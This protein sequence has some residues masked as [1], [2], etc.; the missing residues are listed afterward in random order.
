MDKEIKDR[1]DR[2]YCACGEEITDN[3]NICSECEKNAKLCPFCGSKMTNCELDLICQDCGEV[4]PEIQLDGK[5]FFDESSK[6]WTIYKV[7]DN[8]IA[9]YTLDTVETF[10]CF[11]AVFGLNN[12]VHG[13]PLKINID[14]NFK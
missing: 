2:K 6:E 14:L 12:K 9:Y 5:P 10:R 11:T 3:N 4:I 7:K 13:M 8:Q 1:H